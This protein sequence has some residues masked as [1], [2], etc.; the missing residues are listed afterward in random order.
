MP[1]QTSKGN[2]S[3]IVGSGPGVP[4]GRGTGEVGLGLRPKNKAPLGASVV[5]S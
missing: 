1:A 3:D 5:E 2:I 4:M